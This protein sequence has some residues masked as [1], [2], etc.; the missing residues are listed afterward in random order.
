MFK[1]KTLVI[2]FA[3]L[4][5][6][7]V[8]FAVVQAE[9]QTKTY[10]TMLVQDDQGPSDSLVLSLTDIAPAPGGSHYEASLVSDDRTKTLNVGKLVV[11]Q[12]VIQGVVQPTGTVEHIFNSSSEGYDGGNLLSTYS[13]IRITEEPASVVKYSSALSSDA[14]PSIRK[15]LSNIVSLNVKLSAA[16]TAADLAKLQTDITVLNTY[17]NDVKKAVDEAAPL[18]DSIGNNANAA[19]KAAPK[20]AGIISGGATLSSD[21]EDVVN[22]LSAVSTSVSDIGNT[23]N[24]TLAGLYVDK[25]IAE[26]S[27]ATNGWDGNSDGIYE[28]RGTAQ[29]YLAAQAMAIFNI[30]SGDL[31]ELAKD[32]E[33]PTPVPTAVPTPA[34]TPVP[35]VSEDDV[36]D[37]TEEE[38]SVLGLGL[39]SVGD[40][41]MRGMIPIFALFGVLL[42]GAGALI[43]HRGSKT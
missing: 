23:T 8:P 5:S 43:L 42:L 6:V 2:L 3:T 20:D 19:V 41:T 36:K 10:G 24:I 15:A 34:P 25:I 1:S 31:P 38:Q 21:I 37:I 16:S 13:N 27:A 12:A 18:T 22:L 26:L 7:A 29:A 4:L 17:A 30:V 40:P 32:K 9:E 28:H 33:A 14:T 35:D 39:P 11:N